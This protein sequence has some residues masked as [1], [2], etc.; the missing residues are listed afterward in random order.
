MR[1][2]NYRR[3]PS[4]RIWVEKVA[5]CEYIHCKC[6][7]EF[8]FR[9]G[10]EFSRDP[11]RK[12]QVWEKE[13]E[14]R[15][16][17]NRLRIRCPEDPK[18]LLVLIPRLMLAFLLMLPVTLLFVLVPPVVLAI[19]ALI[20]L[21]VPVALCQPIS[22][23]QSKA[24]RNLAYLG[25]VVFYPLLCALVMILLFLMVVLYPCLRNSNHH[26]TYDPFD[27]GL[28]HLAVYYLRFA[29]WLLHC[30]AE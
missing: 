11:C 14:I 1:E 19:A 12:R 27:I 10:I 22:S 7:T 21:F 23:L 6:Q 24:L 5:G 4:C 15:G 29:V 16:L 9:C 3:C 28:C 20:A 8:C 2:L 25:V 17:F 26:G 18:A 13:A 30:C